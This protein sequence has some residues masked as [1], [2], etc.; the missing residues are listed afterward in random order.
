MLHVI[1]REVKG[2]NYLLEGKANFSLSEA[3][4]SIAYKYVVVPSSQGN[5]KGKIVK[6][7]WECL[8]GFRP[9]NPGRH[10]NR[11]LRIPES[12]LKANGRTKTKPSW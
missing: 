12:S 8:I 7:L 6:D 5:A 3:S 2:H 4:R 11:C 10:V 9:L 1:F